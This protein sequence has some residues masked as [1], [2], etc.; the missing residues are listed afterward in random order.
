MAEKK[1]ENIWKTHSVEIPLDREKVD[2]KRAYED[3]FQ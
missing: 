3:R 1:K 2:E